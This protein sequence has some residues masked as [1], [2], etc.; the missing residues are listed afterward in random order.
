MSD[1]LSATAA[2]LALNTKLEEDF[3]SPLTAVRGA[4][5][6]LRDHAELSSAERARFVANALAGCD[7]LERGIAEL[8]DSVYTTAPQAA[9]A[10]QTDSPESGADAEPESEYAARIHFLDEQQVVEVD[11][12]DVVF[13]SS[14]EVNALYDELDRRVEASGQRWYFLVNYR[15]CRIWPEAWVAFA[16]RGKKVNVSYSLG[17]VR[18]GESGESRAASH[19]EQA[20][21]SRELALA[22]IDAMRC[23]DQRASGHGAG[24]R[25]LR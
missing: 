6:I 25:G 20:D 11:F 8:A 14:R 22:R 13:S 3:V 21:A 24:L 1:N 16:H 7:R 18:Y 9:A 23:T 5:E 4:L 17:T 2:G 10:K 19:G 12:S 15:N